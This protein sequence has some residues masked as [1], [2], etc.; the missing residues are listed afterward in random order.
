[1]T[2]SDQP[3][4]CGACLGIEPITPVTIFNAP[5][6]NALVYRVGTYG[7]FK[8]TMLAAL[9]GQPA[10]AGLTARTDDDP[11]I[12]LIDAWAAALDVLTFYQERIANEN[13]LRTATERRS[14]LELARAIGYELRPGVAASTVLAYTLETTQGSPPTVKIAAGS[15]AMTTPG[16]DEKP[17][18]FETSGD[19]DAHGA[20]NVLTPRRWFTKL[21]K[22][23]DPSVRLAGI[24][25]NLRLGDPVLI[26][27]NERIGDPTSPLVAIRRIAGLDAPPQN[28]NPAYTD[29]LLD[30]K[31]NGTSQQNPRFFVLH[32]RASLFGAT[33]PD[34]RS[35]PLSARNDYLHKPEG[36]QGAITTPPDWPDFS[37][38]GVSE[39]EP[40]ADGAPRGLY[41]EYRI[42]SRVLRRIDKTIP[43]AGRPFNPP[44][45]NKFSVTWS[46]RL[47]VPED[48]SYSFSIEA[49]GPVQLWVDGGDPIIDTVKQPPTATSSTWQPLR[50]TRR[51]S[52]V[53]KF[54]NTAASPSLKLTWSKEIRGINEVSVTVLGEIGGSQFEP[55]DHG[56]IHLDHVYPDVVAG[57]WAVL[58]NPRA[59]CA[60]QITEAAEDGRAAFGLSTRVTRLKLSGIGLAEFFDDGLR[61]TAVYL[62]SEEMPFGLAPITQALAGSTI[63]VTDAV[64]DLPVGRMLMVAGVDPNG[65]P[66][67]DVVTLAAAAADGAGGTVLTLAQDLAHNYDSART[68]ILGNCVAAT[69]GATIPRP[70]P[71]GGGNGAQA[72]QSFVLKQK[73]LTYTSAATPSGA[74]ST[75]TV[76][77]NDIK[78]TEVPSL[79]GQGAQARVFVTRLA[80]DQTVTVPFGNGITGSRL[81]TGSENVVANYRVGIGLGGLARPGQI[82]IPLTRP[83]G[84]K[85]VANPAAPTG[86][87]DPEQLDG[88]RRN[89]PLTVRTLDRIVS[90]TDYA[91]FARGF[92]G[93]GKASAEMVWSGERRVV[94]LTIA[95]VEGAAAPAD[96]QTYR[97]LRDAIEAA[98]PNEHRVVIDNAVERTFALGAA[99][100]PA[101]GLA[102]AILAPR[103]RQALL[104]GFSFDARDIGQQVTTSE[105]ITRIQNVD[106]VAAVR[107]DTATFAALP[108]VLAG[109]GGSLRIIARR[110]R[111][112][113]G[114][115]VP[116]EILTVDPNSITLTEMAP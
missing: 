42:A 51:Y 12:A 112:A 18:T 36:D 3:F 99:V 13:Y 15:Q 91:D 61:T 88:A 39:T 10:L 60:F 49:S 105:I 52:F 83:V 113:D 17:Q 11:A 14:I 82:N 89:A 62:V 102:F 76:T 84:V 22:S 20:W 33:A 64:G 21:P 23:G 85:A 94:H 40:L 32:Q 72:F 108:F 27:G 96:S 97:H 74:A 79:Y 98:A 47:T 29:V 4:E 45:K 30:A 65:T 71:L 34:W 110:A 50:A 7:E 26:V 46:G 28:G 19:L 55:D 8:E 86:A 78:W 5:G 59:T 37:I 70:E 48:A 9:A 104:D 93:I 116:G 25:L 114:T 111:L 41:A 90:V 77:V 67:A 58:S 57:Q 107:L 115:L 95:G 92:A 43:P 56:T 35:L 69:H 103:V 1:M 75:L 16:Q 66:Q 100:L 68:Q 54:Q 31:L 101:P 87:A 106:G 38:S 73:P 53:L 80:D 6:R 2:A 44:T 109:P 81:P 63:D 24:G